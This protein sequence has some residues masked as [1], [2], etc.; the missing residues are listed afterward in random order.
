MQQ[1]AKRILNN[2]RRGADM[3]VHLQ[4]CAN[5]EENSEYYIKEGNIYLWDLSPIPF[6]QKDVLR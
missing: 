1:L 4:C 6:L 2:D 5:V 3:N